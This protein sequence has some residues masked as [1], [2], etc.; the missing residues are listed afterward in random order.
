V[1]LHP[2]TYR[3]T[4]ETKNLSFTTAAKLADA[5]VPFA[6]QT[7][8]E[9]YV[10]KVRVLVFEAAIAAAHGLG[11]KRTLESITL[12]PAKLLG[13]SGRVGSIEV[14]KDGD[15]ALFDG[16]PFEY[17]T[18]CTGVVIEGEVASRLVR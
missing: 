12:T 13:I 18:H 8:F 10:P 1:L 17:T 15:L 5:G 9:G 16:D 6:I 7:G 2:T 4:S 14:G 11:F 3:A